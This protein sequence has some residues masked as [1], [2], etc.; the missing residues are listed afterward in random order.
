MFYQYCLM[1]GAP[2]YDVVVVGSGAGGLVGAL[3]AADA[4]LRTL[5]VEK[6]DT[7]GGT[8]ALSGAGLWAP[9]NLHV[10]A[11]G[12]PD[13]IELAREY[14]HHTVGERTPQSMQDAFLSAA[15][16][17]IAWLE[18]RGVRFN[19][20]SGYPDYRP[21]LPGGLLTGR[22]I[23]PKTFP[24]ARL[25]EIPAPVRPKL[26]MGHGGPPITDPG[27]QGPEW[28]GQSLIA[29]LLIACQ[30]RGVDLWGSTPFTDLVVSD[31][32][33]TGIRVVRGGDD[34]VVTARLGV[35]LAAG[36][37]ER[38]EAMRKEYSVGPAARADWTLG[39]P[40]NTGD[41]IRA[42]MALG[43][44]TD[45]LEDCWWAPGFVRPDGDVSFLLWERAAPGGIVV[46]RE[47]RRWINEGTD[48]NTFGH[49]MLEAEANGR[50]VIPS[51]WVMDQHFVDTYGFGGLRPGVDTTPWVD[52]GALVRRDTVD[53]LAEAIGAPGL[54]DTV[55]R[56]NADALAGVDSE[57]GRGAE[58]SHERQL[59]WVFHRYPGIAGPHE[60]P[61]PCLA[62]ISTGPF[63]AGQVVLADLG[64]KGGLVCDE[65]AH[66]LDE[67]GRRIPGLYACGNT[68]ASMMGHAYPGPGACITPAMAFGHVAVQDMA[69]AVDRTPA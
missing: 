62:P 20:M 46:D 56:W 58:G 26:A 34:V 57:L 63:Y 41:A 27:P 59:L 66:V 1:S 24:H 67:S 9:A 16:D 7:F 64:T 31:G 52:A 12:Q 53:E 15:A 29:Q 65:T 30:T 43:A 19:Y 49:R 50:P 6:A 37:F 47:G 14:M 68:M 22:A 35:L 17:V 18:T 40:E 25:G 55:S 61:N 33:V 8:T 54:V 36:G 42:G 21:D 45:L 32:R 13:S 11:A 3:T 28:G 39:V 10:L 51:W 44:K 5:V 69:G 60:H 48:Y 38:N 2:E 23:T 4:G